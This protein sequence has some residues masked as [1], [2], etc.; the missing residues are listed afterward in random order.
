L[1]RGDGLDLHVVLQFV[2][3]FHDDAVAYT[4]AFRDN[5]VLPVVLR[6]DFN[7]GGVDFIV[8]VHEIDK[9]LVL[10]FDR[11][12]L[13]YENSVALIEKDKQVGSEVRVSHKVEANAWGSLKDMN[14]GAFQLVKTD[15]EG[16]ELAGAEFN[17]KKLASA[18]SPAGDVG[19]VISATNSAVKFANLTVVELENG[20]LKVLLD[21]NYEGK[22]KMEQGVL[23]VI[24]KKTPD[25]PNPVNPPTPD[26]PTPVVP[27]T[28]V[29]PTPVVPPTPDNPTPLVPVTPIPE[30]P[31]PVIPITPTPTPTTPI[32]P[33]T[34]STITPTP[35]SPKTPDGVVVD[36][37]KTPQGKV[38]K[39]NKPK[40]KNNQ[41]VNDDDT[42]LGGNKG[43]KNLPKTGGT[44]TVWYYVAGIGLVLV[45][46]LVLIRRKKEK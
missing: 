42:P 11:A 25:V 16:T 37:D 35:N 24:N 3:T 44:S 7:L 36:E 27:P 4:E 34:P 9:L 23:S 39:T 12:L 1:L 32:T 22:A 26:N 41:I 15:T 10:N 29:N 14:Y 45:G 38:V 13:L 18:Q 46:G 6:H 19:T 5:V 40:G 8:L 28:P 21:G 31:T 33:A 20:G 30:N 43:K 2:Y 17:L